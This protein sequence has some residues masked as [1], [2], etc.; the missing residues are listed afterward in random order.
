VSNDFSK[1]RKR[2]AGYA[3][4]P[5]PHGHLSPATALEQ[6]GAPSIA[7]AVPL[8]EADQLVTQLS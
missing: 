2:A 7:V 1:P 6:L 4:H 3:L 5:T 8:L